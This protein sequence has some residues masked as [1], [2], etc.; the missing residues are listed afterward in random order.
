[1]PV[2]LTGDVH[3]AIP[4]SDRRHASESESALAVAYARIAARHDLQVTL[5][6]TG[7]AAIEDRGDLEPLLAMDNVEIGGHGWDAFSPQLRYRVLRRLSGSQ[8]GPRIWQR[9]WTIGRTCTTLERLTG[10][11]VRSW[12]NHAYLHDAETPGL[13]AEHGVRVWSDEVDLDRAGPYRHATGI[14]VLPMNTTP[15][16]EHMFHG[17]LTPEELGDDSGR[18]V[19]TP[20]E[21]CD[22]VCRQTAAIVEAG[23]TATILAHPLCLKVADDWATFERLCAFVARFP[24]S[25]AADAV[26]RIEAAPDAAGVAGGPDVR[27]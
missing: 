13:L 3:H 15:D 2:V 4:S 26:E 7:R 8:H 24:S 21:W 25:T 16:H 12:R 1:M 19:Y 17:D 9:R 23:G 5:F 20:A 14:A 6:V 27:S 18:E 22:R 11:T 10:R